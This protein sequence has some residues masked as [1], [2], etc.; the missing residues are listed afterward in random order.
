M[1]PKGYEPKKRHGDSSR[2]QFIDALRAVL[3]LKPLYAAERLSEY[4]VLPNDG[5][6]RI[7]A[8]LG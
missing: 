2:A 1:P 4:A 7:G 8:R 5:N 6:R 3:G